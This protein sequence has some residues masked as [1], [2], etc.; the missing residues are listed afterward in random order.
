MAMLADKS[1]TM[2]SSNID[3]TKRNIDTEREEF[4]TSP[5]P[6]FARRRTE[7]AS[8]S[9]DHSSSFSVL[10]CRCARAEQVGKGRDI[11][12][13]TLAQDGVRGR[14]PAERCSFQRAVTTATACV[15]KKSA[16]SPSSTL[17]AAPLRSR[18]STCWRF[19]S[20]VGLA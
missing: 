17:R 3:M 11:E 16:S 1:V 9:R 19:K 5:S 15:P 13:R 4:N 6:N 8:I 7:G 12:E 20:P 18:C 2:I 10:V 14:M